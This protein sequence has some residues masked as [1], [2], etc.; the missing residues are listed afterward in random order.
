MKILLTCHFPLQGSGSGIY[1]LNLAH[2]LVK[3]GHKACIIMPENQILPDL[4]KKGVLL[5][6]VYFNGIC[7]D[8][9]DFN[10]P[11]F[12]THPHSS[13]TFDNLSPEQLSQYEN[14]FTSKIAHVMDEFM[15]N[16]AHSGH[17]WLISY[18]L[19]KFDIPLV[20]TCH[21]TDLI[22]YKNLQKFRPE[23]EAAIARAY[24]CITISNENEKI[25]KELFPAH[26]N[27][28]KMILNG[29]N[30]DIFY[31]GDTSVRE[32][33][34][35]FG[36]TGYYSKI[37]SFVGKFTSFKGIDILL[38]AAVDFERDDTAIILAGD[39]EIFNEMKE[40]ARKNC[41][42]HVYFVHN[43][44]QK[45]LR[46]LYGAAS[47]SL[48]TSRV[49][50]FGLVI[51]EAMACGAPVVASD[52]G[53]AV[54]ILNED[55]GV[56]FR[57]EDPKDLAEKVNYVMDNVDKYDRDAIAKYALDNFSHSLSIKK[58]YKLYEDAIAAY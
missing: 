57:S 27:K 50:S 30:P 44:Q 54:D 35:I 42:H 13:N 16:I 6:P 28:C 37:I 12:T 32:V 39:G 1:T 34:D 21:G 7:E 8:A 26:D 38:N 36:I 47:V 23:A 43:Q 56:L 58:V 3:L 2:A 20:L 33:L 11:C 29:Y 31:P 48:L 46:K 49:E 17:I 53:G 9:L 14:A 4:D 5:R 15:P 40:L 51:I 55:V 45:V 41:L 52:D 22:G 25:V 24:A 19:T 10:F 18:Y